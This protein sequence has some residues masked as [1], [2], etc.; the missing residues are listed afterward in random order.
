V[1]AIKKAPTAAIVGSTC[2][3]QAVPDPHRQG[4]RVNAGQEQRNHQF[5]ATAISA[6]DAALRDVKA[7]LLGVPVATLLGRCGDSVESYRS[8][9][10]TTYSD[11][12][13]RDRLAGW[14]EARRLPFG[15]GQDR[16]RA[17][18]RPRPRQDRAARD[19]RSRSF[20][21]RQCPHRCARGLISSWPMGV[22]RHI[23][24]H[25]SLNLNIQLGGILNSNRPEPKDA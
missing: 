1:T 24:F 2:R 16:R 19:R 9:G 8:G 18:A 23:S 25:P 22:A 7:K 21:R 11:E 6:I 5:A 15:E 13:L 14:V 3:L 17:W 4:L 12:R 10:F 20:R